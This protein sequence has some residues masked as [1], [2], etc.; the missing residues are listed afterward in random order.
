ME[1]KTTHHK[2]L[3]E[4]SIIQVHGK[5]ASEAGGKTTKTMPR[6]QMNFYENEHEYH[7]L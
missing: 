7:H 4:I 1:H 2:T 6:A 5:I 3:P